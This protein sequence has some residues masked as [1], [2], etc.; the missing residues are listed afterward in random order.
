MQILGGTLGQLIVPLACVLLFIRRGET[1]AVA[2]SAFWG[3]ENLLYIAT[4]MADARASALPLVGSDESDWTILFSNWGVLHLD[5]TIAAWTRA[6][7]WIGMLATIGWL[8]WMHL[9]TQE[10]E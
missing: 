6:A 8:A 7:G 3:F 1:L 10:R 4:Y 9:K 2:F 5:R